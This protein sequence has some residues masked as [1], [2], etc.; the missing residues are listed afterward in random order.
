MTRTIDIEWPWVVAPELLAGG[1]IVLRMPRPERWCP[2]CEGSGSA[3]EAACRHCAGTGLIAEPKE[4]ELLLPAGLS[5]GARVPVP[6]HGIALP[7]VDRVGDLT[8]TVYPDP[9]GGTR[10]VGMDLYMT[11][12][13]TPL[14]ARAGVRRVLRTPAG[15]VA[16]EIPPRVADGSVFEVRGAGLPDGLGETGSLHVTVR[17]PPA[18]GPHRPAREV[19]SAKDALAAGR[20]REAELLLRPL[21]EADPQDGE[22]H[23]LLGRTLLARGEPRE[24]VVPLRRAI[25][26]GRFSTPELHVTLGIA[27]LHLDLPGL[28]V[29]QAAMAL[30]ERPLLASAGK[31]LGQALPRFLSEGPRAKGWHEVAALSATALPEAQRRFFQTAARAFLERADDSRDPGPLL[32]VGGV[33]LAIHGLTSRDY[34]SA[35]HGIDRLLGLHAR[36]FGD[37]G[38]AVHATALLDGFLARA[39][40]WARVQLAEL[41]AADGRF[42][43]AR[44]AI[45]ADAPG[46]E[47]LPDATDAGLTGRFVEVA[48]RLRALAGEQGSADA[49]VA[50]AALRR[51]TD[52]LLAESL[53]NPDETRLHLLGDAVRDAWLAVHLDSTDRAALALLADLQ[54]D[55]SGVVARLLARGG[56]HRNAFFQNTFDA[57][58]RGA[59]PAAALTPEDALKLGSRG[60]MEHYWWVFDMLFVGQVP[61]PGEFLADAVPG[62]YVLTSY[63][64]LLANPELGDYDLLPLPNLQDYSLQRVALG[65]ARVTVALRGGGT[66]DYG[67]VRSESV[68]PASLVRRLLHEA[69]WTA[70]PA[71]ELA[72]LRAGYGGEEFRSPPEERPALPGPARELLEAT[73]LGE[74]TFTVA[75]PSADAGTAYRSPFEEGDGPAPRDDRFC[76]GCGRELEPDWG[77]CA[78][79][80]RDVRALGPEGRR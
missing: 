8:L 67:R 22:V 21:A 59:L 72:D 3:G 65:Q 60:L 43:H 27:Y 23:Y 4:L 55:L 15:R 30:R 6:S 64:L 14:E 10:V 44:E 50:A 76:P 37:D 80:G 29:W 12:T 2:A 24:A 45:L 32:L 74:A 13:L 70:L 39:P 41:A 26:E 56:A 38:P 78:R 63:R 34:G 5:H 57:L 20:Y 17:V 49:A 1:G 40:L 51:R 9:R 77:F 54:D 31:L 73:P 11:C 79:C 47:A 42:D 48:D 7:G 35:A 46:R 75:L 58:V 52:A 66:L 28:A 69:R 61:L 19:S 68:P 71:T 18:A 36:G 16:V 53:E 25:T 62:C 33:L